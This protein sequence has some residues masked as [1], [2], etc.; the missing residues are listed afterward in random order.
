MGINS[1]H[2]GLEK[3]E[4]KMRKRTE[5]ERRPLGLWIE[6]MPFIVVKICHHIVK[7]GRS[8]AFLSAK[9]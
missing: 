6:C 5:R 4:R 3:K 8:Y 9:H 2:K 7:K 1:G